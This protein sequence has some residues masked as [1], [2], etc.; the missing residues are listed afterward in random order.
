MENETDYQGIDYSFGKSNVSDDGI[1]YGVIPVED[2]CEFWC[3][4]S[5][6]NY[7]EASC[8]DCDS[9]LVDIVDFENNNPEIETD[10]FKRFSE[11][12]C[13][14]WVCTNCEM[15]VGGE[16]AF[17]ESPFS[18][19]L[20][21]DTYQAEQGQDSCDIFIMKSKYFTFAQ[22]CS[23]CAPGAC[24]LPIPLKEN[25]AINK[26][27]CLHHDCFLDGKA[28]YKV[29]SIETGKEIKAKRVKN[30]CTNC[31]GK[32]TDTYKRLSVSRQEGIIKT[33]NFI[34]NAYQHLYIA[35]DLENF[36]CFR[37]CGKGTE[38][39]IEYIEEG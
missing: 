20:D 1:H 10:D 34:A 3:E 12:D 27:F 30:A 16:Y 18:H 28:P 8:P 32:G 6:L 23:P 9:D 38:T 31:K 24:Y 14:D 19:Y 25:H 2:V 33:R 11:F 7:G 4:D 36:K 37:C 21:D 35:K 29:Y 26:C 5:E 17:P 13:D 22:F 15:I 39:N